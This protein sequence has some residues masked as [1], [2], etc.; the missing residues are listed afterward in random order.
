MKK[1]PSKNKTTQPPTNPPEFSTTPA[2]NAKQGFLFP[3]QP[4]V[5]KQ[6]ISLTHKQHILITITITIII[7]IIITTR[8]ISISTIR[9]RSTTLEDSD[10]CC[11]LT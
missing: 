8:S 5:T 1:K 11:F 9:K 10:D 4:N 7:I 3:A 6:I 2:A